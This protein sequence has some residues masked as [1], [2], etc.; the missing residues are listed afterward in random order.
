MHCHATNVKTVEHTHTGAITCLNAHLSQ[1]KPHAVFCA[2]ATG[3]RYNVET[4]LDRVNNVGIDTEDK[5]ERSPLHGAVL[6][7]NT[8]VVELLVDRCVG[9]ISLSW[10]GGGSGPR[11]G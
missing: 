2:C 9:Q 8:E 7:N 6:Y 4:L 3:T 5:K 1:S 10:R 11:A